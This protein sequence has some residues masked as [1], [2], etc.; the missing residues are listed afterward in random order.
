MLV[1]SIFL[2]LM[3][4]NI[5]LSSPSAMGSY[6]KNMAYGHLGNGPLPDTKSASTMILGFQASRT[7]RNK[8]LCHT[9]K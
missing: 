1:F 2:L 5:F 7:V 4:H 9:S 8:C 3:K 6:S